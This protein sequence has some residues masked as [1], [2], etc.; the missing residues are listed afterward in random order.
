MSTGEQNYRMTGLA[1]PL[2]TKEGFL[3]PVFSHP[4][5]NALLVERVGADGRVADFVPLHLEEGRIIPTVEGDSAIGA[6]PHW[7]FGLKDEVLVGAGQENRDLLKARLDGHFLQERPMLGVEVAEFLELRDMRLQFA[8]ATFRRL[9]T[10][11][12]VAADRWRDLSILTPD[13]RDALQRIFDENLAVQLRPDLR[14]VTARVQG[15]SVLI[16]GLDPDGPPE[17]LGLVDRAANRILADLPGLYDT[18][19]RGWSVSLVKSSQPVASPPRLHDLSQL[20]AL[21]YVA[22]SNFPQFPTRDQEIIGGIGIYHPHHEQ[23]FIHQSI[24][25]RGPSFALFQL[26]GGLDR[27]LPSLKPTRRRRPIGLASRISSAAK[28]RPA[29]Q[30]GQSRYRH[31]TIIVASRSPSGFARPGLNGELRDAIQTIASIWHQGLNE[32]LPF[33]TNLF[34]RARGAT[35][36]H[37]DDAWTQIYERCQRFGISRP[38]G[39]RI[40]GPRSGLYEE[41]EKLGLGELLF[42]ELRPLHIDVGADPRSRPVDAAV[43][44]EFGESPDGDGWRHHSDVI[45]ELLR[46]QGWSILEAGGNL[47]FQ[48]QLGISGAHGQFEIT[49]SME[50]YPERARYVFNELLHQDIG[51]ISRLV[52]T[53]EASVSVVLNSLYERHELPATARDLSLFSAEE[54]TIWTLLGSQM[55]RFAGW[56]MARSR[57][58]YFALLCQAAVQR[59]QI[60]LDNPELLVETLHGD[61]LGRRVHLV[62]SQMTYEQGTSI[63]VLRL[64]PRNSNDFLPEFIRKIDRFRLI[65]NRS[66]PSITKASP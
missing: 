38:V 66:G 29:E 55:R 51:G 13:L 18:P 60:E 36:F 3:V 65:I 25:F 19:R 4:S 20:L 37:M 2:G 50:R 11:K 6:E 17:I 57:T 26:D 22:D 24:E 8:N 16:H 32:R 62:S 41:G 58:Q 52:A 12:P 59:G 10:S 31:P 15:G 27:V 53:E 48:R 1:D 40:I 54:G 33:R 63:I 5:S 42:P 23:Q 9:Q 47:G 61:D 34:L 7:A 44:I 43:L 39:L 14:Y 30:A 56:M 46:R 64:V 21:A 49:T 35:H 28:L 45:E